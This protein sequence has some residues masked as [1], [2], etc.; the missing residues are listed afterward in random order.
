MTANYLTFEFQ[1]DTPEQESS[2]TEVLAGATW[3]TGFTASGSV[4]IIFDLTQQ[5]SKD[6]AMRQL[7]RLKKCIDQSINF[8]K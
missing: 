5:G 8:L 1:H 7:E 6:A 2:Y 4:M 3:P